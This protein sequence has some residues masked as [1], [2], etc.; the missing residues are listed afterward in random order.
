MA[1]PKSSSSVSQK[2]T[3]GKKRKGK[4]KKSYGPK[5]QKPKTYKGQGR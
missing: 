1:K 3:F 4:S 2:V 5:E